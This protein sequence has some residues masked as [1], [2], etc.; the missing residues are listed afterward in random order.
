MTVA[1]LSVHLI[2]IKMLNPGMKSMS[3]NS[4]RTFIYC[5]SLIL[6]P[7][8]SNLVQTLLNPHQV[9]KH[10]SFLSDGSIVSAN[11]EKDLAV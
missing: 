6:E 4:C 10:Q 8:G 1:Y 9:I 3:V 5:I 11:E 7:A 2:S